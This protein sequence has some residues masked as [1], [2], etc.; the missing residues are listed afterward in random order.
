MSWN[1]ILEHDYLSC[2]INYNQFE[3]RKQEKL[4]AIKLNSKKAEIDYD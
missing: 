4:S 2:D 1:E 3:E